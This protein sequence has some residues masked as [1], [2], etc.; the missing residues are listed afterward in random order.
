MWFCIF[1][2]KVFFLDSSNINSDI[3][4]YSTRIQRRCWTIM[5]TVWL[6]FK[7]LLHNFFFSQAMSIYKS[8]CI[9]R[10]ITNLFKLWIKIQQLSTL[11]VLIL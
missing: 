3:S 9:S 1:S 5:K 8:E 10:I 4:V 7:M 11:T 6:K 2:Q